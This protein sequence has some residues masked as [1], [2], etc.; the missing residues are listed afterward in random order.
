[1]PLLRISWFIGQTDQIIGGKLIK[2]A[3]SD[4]IID[5]QFG[6][7]IF[8][9]AVSLLGFVDNLTNFGLRQIAV[10]ANLTQTL[11]VIHKNHLRN[12]RKSIRN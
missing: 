1:M 11:P 7:A 6:P 10:F 5:F 8:N 4:E 12:Y 2:S 3:K 9:V